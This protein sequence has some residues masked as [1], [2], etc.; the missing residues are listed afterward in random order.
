MQCLIICVV[1]ESVRTEPKQ[2]TRTGEHG[3]SLGFA[4]REPIQCEHLAGLDTLE[5]RLID[6]LEHF[7]ASTN[8]PL[9][10]QGSQ[11]PK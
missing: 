3:I 7:F 5:R 2:E 4:G 1:S 6:I 11:I 8:G 10:S 9:P